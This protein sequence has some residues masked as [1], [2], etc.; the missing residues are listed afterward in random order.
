MKKELCPG[1]QNI[2]FD[3]IQSLLELVSV[4]WTDENLEI[5]CLGM[6]PS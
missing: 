3:T 6:T 1:Y 2:G 5:L 4:A